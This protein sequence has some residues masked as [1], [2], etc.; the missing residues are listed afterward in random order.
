M[1]ETISPISNF[2]FPIVI[3]TT[4]DEFEGSFEWTIVTLNYKF[5]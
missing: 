3:R 1:S 5:S 4:L 2:P